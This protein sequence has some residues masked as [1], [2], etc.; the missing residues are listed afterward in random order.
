MK[1]TIAK[2]ADSARQ[3]YQNVHNEYG[4]RIEVQAGVKSGKD[5]LTNYGQA[6]GGTVKMKAP[7]GQISD[8]AADQVEHYKSRGAVVVP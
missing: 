3:A 5:Y 7:N 6:F 1:D 8:V 2:K 4:R